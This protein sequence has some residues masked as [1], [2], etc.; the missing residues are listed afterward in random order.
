MTLRDQIQHC[1][2]SRLDNF[3][4]LYDDIKLLALETMI[5]NNAKG[6][7]VNIDISGKMKPFYNRG[8]ELYFRDLEIYLNHRGNGLKIETPAVRF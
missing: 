1:W 7:I 8:K 3:E 6:E 5:R 2:S 4:M